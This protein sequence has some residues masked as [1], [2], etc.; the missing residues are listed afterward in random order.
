[1]ADTTIRVSTEIAG[2]LATLARQRGCTVGE[3]V[4]DFAAST[5]TRDE[6]E[7]RHAAATA[8]IRAHLVRDFNDED[9]AAGE[10]MW[11]D[12]AAGRLTTIG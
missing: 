9:I 11:R 12:L 4:A 8:Y 6:I 10:Q 2:R 7:T 3:L 5:T 1:M